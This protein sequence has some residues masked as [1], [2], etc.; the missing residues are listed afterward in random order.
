[1]FREFRFVASLLTNLVYA[2]AAAL[3]VLAIGFAA[4]NAA[5]AAS[6]D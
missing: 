2:E 5:A 6:P 1:L 4:A 3:V